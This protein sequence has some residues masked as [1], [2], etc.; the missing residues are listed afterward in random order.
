M[1]RVS[2]WKA[3]PGVLALGGAVFLLTGSAAH[4]DPRPGAVEL[5]LLVD[6]CPSS[7]SAT[8]P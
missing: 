3:V 5:R 2:P 7:T 4:A 8:A 6:D 1:T